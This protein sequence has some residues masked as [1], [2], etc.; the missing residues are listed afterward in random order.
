[1]AGQKTNTLAIVALV[2]IVVFPPLGLL[3][4]IVARSQ[5]KNSNEGGGGLALAALILNG[6]LTLAAIFFVAILVP[7]MNKFQCRAK[8]SEG[9]ISLKSLYVAEASFQAEANRYGTLEEVQYR[10][11]SSQP[12]YKIEIVKKSDSGFTARAT[13]IRDDVEGDIWEIDEKNQ[14]RNIENACN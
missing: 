12:R 1:M 6:L 8:Q 11:M 10:S 7:Q 3:L 4:A 2:L 9:K 5:I 13:G 14:I